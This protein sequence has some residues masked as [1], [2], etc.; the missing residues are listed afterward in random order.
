[1][2][3][4][5]FFSKMGVALLAGREFNAG[6]GREAPQ[7]AVVNQTWTDHF[8]PDESPLGKRF[9]QSWGDGVELDIEI[10][11]LV[12]DTQYSSVRQDPPRLFYLPWQQLTQLNDMSFYVRSALPAEEIIPELRR[13][14]TGIDPDLPLE[15][16][17][18]MRDQVRENIMAD[19][20]TVQ[21]AALFAMLATV[22]A[23]MGLYGVMAYS[24]AQRVREIGIRMALG[25]DRSRIRSLVM[26]D[27]LR[28]LVIGLAIGIPVALGLAK[29]VESQLYG[30][31][32]F[33]APVLIV[34]VLV[35]VAAALT[36]GIVPSQRATRVDPVTSL[37]QD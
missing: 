25:A 20:I 15:N 26:K 2:I 9:A 14:M 8:S 29:L 21:L 24:V 12:Q 27:L 32:A 23:M 5:G 31:T 6:D 10:V 18:T 36:A 34:A 1:M 11:G 13:V 7:V 33:D 17:W 28:L 4:P 16:L 37:R 35:L 3:S 22:L 19:R 30:I